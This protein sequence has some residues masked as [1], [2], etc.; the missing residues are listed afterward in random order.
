MPMPVQRRIEKPAASLLFIGVVHLRW[1]VKCQR[2]A[3]SSRIILIGN[4]QLSKHFIGSDIAIGIPERIDTARLVSIQGSSSRDESR[5]P[6]PKALRLTIRTVPSNMARARRW[7]VSIT[8]NAQTVSRT[9]VPSQVRPHHSKKGRKE[10]LSI[11]ER[12]SHSD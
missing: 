11:C 6:T 9:V 3:T 4:D 7:K 10:S 5:L 8:G 2:I 12:P 1:T